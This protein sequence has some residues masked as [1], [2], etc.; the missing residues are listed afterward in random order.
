[1][2][3]IVTTAF[4]FLMVFFYGFADNSCYAQ[5]RKQYTA[6]VYTMSKN[7]YQGVLEAVNDRGLYLKRR[8]GDTSVFVQANQIRQ[9]KLRKKGKVSVGTT[10]GFFTGLAI[11][12]GAVISLH[13][14]DKL[15]NTIYT[16]G[17]ALFTFTTTAIGG[18]L[19]SSP[20]E[21]IQISGRNEDF[22]QV[23]QKLKSY[24][25][26]GTAEPGKLP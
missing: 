24:S 10:I 15:E 12:T 5:K 23:L 17:A 26:Q 1:M 18:A 25:V 16:V 21:V 14:S 13:S 8:V 9:I 6:K 20:D 2:K 22:L 11:G 3:A 7:K 4:T 19:S